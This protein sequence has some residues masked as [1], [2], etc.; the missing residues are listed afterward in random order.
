MNLE[1]KESNEKLVQCGDEMSQLF[2]ERL[3]AV[4]IICM[5]IRSD[6]TLRWMY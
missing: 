1:L 2:S 4:G 6:I 5:C 3:F